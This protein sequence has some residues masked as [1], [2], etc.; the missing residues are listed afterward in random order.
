MLSVVQG[1][2]KAD[3]VQTKLKH[4]HAFPELNLDLYTCLQSMVNIHIYT[5]H[6]LSFGEWIGKATQVVHTWRCIGTD[7][8]VALVHSH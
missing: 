5:V 1:Q 6:S 7:A 8:H 4:Q 3:L 2:S